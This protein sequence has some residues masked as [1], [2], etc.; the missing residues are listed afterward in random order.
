M[1]IITVADTS[2]G[3]SDKYINYP[4][5][6]QLP[7]LLRGFNV[8]ITNDDGDVDYCSAVWT[9]GEADESNPDIFISIDLV[10]YNGWRPTG[11]LVFR[12]YGV[13]RYDFEEREEYVEMVTPEYVQK[14]MDKDWR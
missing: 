9:P 13:D 10:S 7:G 4:T 6:T 14:Y 2:T 3:W 8:E 12:G 1:N 5:M 11:R